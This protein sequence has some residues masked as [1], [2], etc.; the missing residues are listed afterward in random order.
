VAYAIFQDI[1]IRGNQY[2]PFGNGGGDQQTIKR[3]AAVKIQPIH[4]PQMFGGYIDETDVIIP[5]HFRK[6]GNTLGKTGSAYAGL[7]SDFSSGSHADIQ[8]GRQIIQ[9]GNGICGQS[10]FILK[11]PKRDMRIQKVTHCI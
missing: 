10:V 9:D 4:T 7:D 11:N 5:N 8:T 6:A 3:I 1:F 2:R